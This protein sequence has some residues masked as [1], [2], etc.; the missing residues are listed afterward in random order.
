MLLLERFLANSR[1]GKPLVISETGGDALAGHHGPADELFTE[2]KQAD[3]QRQQLTILDRVPYVRGCIP[4]LLYDYRTERRRTRF[5]RGQSVCALTGIV[6]T[7]V[8]AR[9]VAVPG[10]EPGKQSPA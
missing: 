6:A 10:L 7:A 1:P 2:E 9:S 5:Q 3:I 4:W 8:I